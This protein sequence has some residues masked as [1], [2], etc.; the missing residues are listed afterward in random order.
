MTTASL[1]KVDCSTMLAV[2]YTHTH[3]FIQLFYHFHCWLKAVNFDSIIP[4]LYRKTF[5]HTNTRDVQE[6]EWR[7]WSSL[8]CLYKVAVRTHTSQR[9]AFCWRCALSATNAREVAMGM[10]LHSIP[11]HDSEMTEFSR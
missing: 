11:R 6:N 4:P 8:F 2:P 3:T 10:T 7:V 9:E 1:V 5:S